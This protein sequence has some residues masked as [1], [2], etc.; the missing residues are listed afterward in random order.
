M[1]PHVP[2][3][4]EF[5]SQAGVLPNGKRRTTEY[6]TLKELKEKYAQYVSGEGIEFCCR[7]AL[8]C[9]VTVFMLTL[10]QY[11]QVEDEIKTWMMSFN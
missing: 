8:G 7:Q 6:R 3:G 10:E 1:D 9:S 5:D 2:N 11:E 4:L